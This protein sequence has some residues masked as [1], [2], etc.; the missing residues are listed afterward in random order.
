MN[1]RWRVPSIPSYIFRQLTLHFQP[2]CRKRDNQFL[3]VGKQTA[4]SYLSVPYDK[5]YRNNRLYETALMGIC[6]R[7]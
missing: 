4:E 7:P 6:P 5:T 1:S 2:V 3:P